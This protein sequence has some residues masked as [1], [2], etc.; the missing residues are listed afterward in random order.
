VV[1]EG[2]GNMSA[3]LGPIDLTC[4]APAYPVVRACERLGFRTPLDVR[5]SRMIVFLGF[6]H[7]A[8]ASQHCCCGET[9]PPLERYLFEF[10]DGREASYWLGQCPR[11]HTIHWNDA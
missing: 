2:E 1:I 9:L 7:P 3:H 8:A 11:C 5:W 4:D 6:G 10:R